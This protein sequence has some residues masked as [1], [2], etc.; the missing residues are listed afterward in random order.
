[1]SRINDVLAHASST[2]SWL[3]D[4]AGLP[5]LEMLRSWL[6][7]DQKK[8]RKAESPMDIYRLQGSIAVLERIVFLKAEIRDYQKRLMSGEVKQVKEGKHGVV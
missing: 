8:L 1:M 7:D 3:D 5:T 2:L 6:E 4:P